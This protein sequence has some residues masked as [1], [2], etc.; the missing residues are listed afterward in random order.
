M[1]NLQKFINEEIISLVYS[2][3]VPLLKNT[4]VEKSSLNLLD[5]AGKDGWAKLKESLNLPTKP[6][7][8]IDEPLP[9]WKYK[10]ILT[11][12]EIAKSLVISSVISAV[13]DN[14]QIVSWGYIDGYEL[15]YWTLMPVGQFLLIEDDGERKFNVIK[16]IKFD[17]V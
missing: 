6:E 3:V 17:F 1:S 13:P 14:S 12:P 10:Y 9:E 15:L 8:K 11:T 5:I 16:N 7:R 4:P 2:R